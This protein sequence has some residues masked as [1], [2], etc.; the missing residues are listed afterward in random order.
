M[1]I[2]DRKIPSLLPK[3]SYSRLHELYRS[4]LTKRELSNIAKLSVFKWV[5]V[6]FLICGH[7]S[8]AVTESILSRVQAAGMFFCEEFTY[9]V[10]QFATKCTAVKFV[11]L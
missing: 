1:Y 2:W 4:V 6:S 5:L 7:E 9:T 10:S 11:K 8:W 3:S